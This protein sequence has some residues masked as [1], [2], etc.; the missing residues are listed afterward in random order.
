MV[1]NFCVF[2]HALSRKGFRR[3]WSGDAEGHRGGRLCCRLAVAA[4]ALCRC[5][6]V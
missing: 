4:V 3:W 1:N 6:G 5:G 2:C